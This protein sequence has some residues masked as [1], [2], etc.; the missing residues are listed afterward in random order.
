MDPD[1]NQRIDD[2]CRSSLELDPEERTSYIERACGGDE[3]LKD[4]VVERI[5]Q[6]DKARQYFAGLSERL[7]LS[8]LGDPR[9]TISIGQQLGKYKVESLI[10]QGGMGMVYR[11]TDEQLGRPVA[12]KFLLARYVDDE[13][14]NTRFIREARAAATL[15]HP[16]ILT[17]HDIIDHEG[18]SVIVME[19]IDGETLR[20]KLKRGPIDIQTAIDYIRQIAEGLAVAHKAGIVHRDLK[21][22]NI[23]VTRHG[24]VKILDFGL[25]KLKNASMVTRDGTIMGTASYLSPELAKGN[26]ADAR[27]DI[28]SMGAILYEM[29]TG[30][31]PFQ[32][33]SFHAVLYALVNEPLI[34]VAGLRPGIPPRLSHAVSKALEK[35]KHKRYQD[36]QGFLEDLNLVLNRKEEVTRRS[37]AGRPVSSDSSPS[38]EAEGTE[39]GA[40]RFLIVDDEPDVELLI[41]QQFKKKIRAGEW[42]VAFAENGAVA[43]EIIEEE[44][45]FHII[46]T[47]LQMPVMDGHALLG[48]LN[49]AEQ[50]FKALVLSAFGDMHN[51]RMAMNLGAYD[52]LFKPI[53][54]ND[55]E[56]TVEKTIREV[57]QLRRERISRKRLW[58]FE[59]EL[60]IS[61]RIQHA[62]LPKELP[63]SDDVS[64]YA[65]TDP[66]FEINGDFYDFFYLDDHRL[67][68]FIG[69]VSGRG[70]PSALFMTMCHTLLKADARR[71]FQPDVCMGSLNEFLYPESFEDIFIT[72]FYG[73]LDLSTG[74]VSYCN[75]GHNPPLI[76]RAAG[77]VE[78]I[79]WEGDIGIGLK[80]QFLYNK[81]SLPL[82]PGDTLFL[83]TDGL[84]KSTDEAG[85][86]YDTSDLEAVLK[87]Y[88]K[89]D[90][91]VQIRHVVRSIDRFTSG[92]PQADD[93]T[94]L[95]VK[96]LGTA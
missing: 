46:L 82:H 48:E 45:D 53:D 3:G 42:E 5:A 91:S 39:A 71:G 38:F 93:L 23:M 81:R 43:L 67:G 64:V 61:R 30:Q 20:Q 86:L 62:V 7:G 16:A 24:G 77:G 29:L 41:R 70:L 52:F 75:A 83:Y 96:W 55:F 25:A 50:P 76:V 17:V 26:E 80:E 21:P 57:R 84:L 6:Y 10:G 31:S 28:W 79:E 47:D 34:P 56:K 59:E 58:S 73:I 14:A 72:V 94:M 22:A 54:F 49:K 92:T 11:A 44:E 88:A 19:Y 35:D 60:S 33:E 13:R 51:V 36:I 1:R 18:L 9:L 12:L 40:I 78:P 8:G 2:I 68:F 65:F 69:D 37:P 95:G 85:T 87:K 89:A 4:A 90:P 63:P 74:L 15:N 66:A 27:A 32:G